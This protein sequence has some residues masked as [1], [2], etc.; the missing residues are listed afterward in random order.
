MSAGVERDDGAPDRA[1]LARHDQRVEASRQVALAAGADEPPAKTVAAADQWLERALELRATRG[2]GGRRPAAKAGHEFDSS[3]HVRQA[4]NH[5]PAGGLAALFAAGPEDERHGA[6]VAGADDLL[7][8]LDAQPLMDGAGA[9]TVQPSAATPGS[10]D[11]DL[12]EL[13]EL[14]VD[15]DEEQA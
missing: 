4:A 10:A 15:P 3:T 5:A 7:E 14:Y 6:P 1:L 12:R 9:T 8:F 11:A 13:L 2:R